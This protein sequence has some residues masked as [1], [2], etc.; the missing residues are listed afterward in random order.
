VLSVISLPLPLPGCVCA[1]VH[2]YRAH[3]REKSVKRELSDL[4]SKN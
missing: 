2:S 1:R 3:F 4:D